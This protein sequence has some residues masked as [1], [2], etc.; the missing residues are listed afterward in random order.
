MK[1]KE[2]ESIVFPAPPP[3]NRSANVE[4]K[5]VQNFR[6]CMKFCRTLHFAFTYCKLECNYYTYE[7]F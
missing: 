4:C 6:Y 3:P 7:N 2:N 5:D 1:T